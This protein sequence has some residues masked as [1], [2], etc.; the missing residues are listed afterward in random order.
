MWLDGPA[1]PPPPDA[2]INYYYAVAPGTESVFR[3]REPLNASPDNR[4]FLALSNGFARRA[5]ADEG[6]E[7]QR[8]KHRRSGHSEPLSLLIPAPR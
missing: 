2:P 6:A 8:P 7:T 3:V 1:P 4:E 5:G